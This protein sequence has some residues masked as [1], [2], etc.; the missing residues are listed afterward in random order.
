MIGDLP[1]SWKNFLAFL[2]LA[3]SIKFAY[4]GELVGAWFGLIYAVGLFYLAW[5]PAPPKTGQTRRV[6]QYVKS[7]DGERIYLSFVPKNYDSMHDAAANGSRY[8][9][10]PFQFLVVQGNDWEMGYGKFDAENNA[11]VRYKFID[12]SSHE[13]IH[14]KPG[15]AVPAFYLI[16]H[17]R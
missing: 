10:K 3:A 1:R 13:R 17:Y 16:D 2:M 15:A 8:L 4:E 5:S 11:I 14:F 7:D 6:K 12:S 9:H